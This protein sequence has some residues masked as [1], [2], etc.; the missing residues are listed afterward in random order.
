MN[1]FKGLMRAFAFILFLSTWTTAQRVKSLNQMLAW[2]VLEYGFHSDIERSYAVDNGLLTPN[3]GTPIDVAVQYLPAGNMRVFTTIPRFSKGIP[4]TLA[5]VSS[6]I[7]DNGP[8]IYPYP[9]YD[10]HINNNAECKG[11]TSA[12]RV[13]IDDCQNMWVIDSGVIEGVNICPPQ[14]LK[15]D[16]KTDTLLHRYQFPSNLYTPS[17]SLLINLAV[18]TYDSPPMGECQ[19][20]MIYVA[21]VTKPGLLVYDSIRDMAWRV[22]NPLMQPD[23]NFVTHTVA[24]ESFDLADGMFA[25]N[26]TPRSKKGLHSERHLYF[27]ALASDTENSV[28]LRLLN[29]HSIWMQNPNAHPEAFKTI[30]K[31]GVQA[32]QEAMDSKGNLYSNSEDPLTVFAWNIYHSP[33]SYNG[34]K[35][36]ANNQEQLQFASGM[37]VV[38]NPYGREELWMLTC[39]FQ[40]VATGKLDPNEI[41]FRIL[42]CKTDDLLRNKECTPL[43]AQMTPYTE[44]PYTNLILS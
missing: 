8:V 33:Y 14:L 19:R 20:Q 2:K 24:G 6:K 18:D 41:N 15:F 11:I 25:L 38:K 37:K 42:A 22:E 35:I 7:G 3:T 40:K 23:P 43:E 44:S 28:P 27:H 26:L 5:T 13:H 10:T 16:L 1:D 31:R 29:D 39:R 9:N 17:D 36:V 34:F 30:G 12:F 32:A 4:Y 21:D